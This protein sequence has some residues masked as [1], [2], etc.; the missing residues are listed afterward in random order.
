MFSVTH[1]LIL[2]KTFEP[3][4][5]PQ[6]RSNRS[7]VHYH[8]CYPRNTLFGIIFIQIKARTYL[9]KSG[10]REMTCSNSMYV[11]SPSSSRSASSNTCRHNNATTMAQG[12]EW[13]THCR[14]DGVRNIF[15]QEYRLVQLVT[16]FCLIVDM[17][18]LSDILVNSFK[19]VF[20]VLF[21]QE[22]FN[23]SSLTLV[24]EMFVKLN[25]SLSWNY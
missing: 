3:I 13:S 20:N 24:T 6:W 21:S 22:G 2:R 11:M 7:P 9:M 5:P 19:T 23:T 15:F 1:P 14:Y 4:P 17:L 25:N 18:V 8:I 16:I 12:G 10:E